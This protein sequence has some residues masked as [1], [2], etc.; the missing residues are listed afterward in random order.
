VVKEN[1]RK[2]T[3][4]RKKFQM[5]LNGNTSLR[6]L[7]IKTPLSTSNEDQSLLAKN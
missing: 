1:T 2:H 4:R 7:C 6:L 3:L 5:L